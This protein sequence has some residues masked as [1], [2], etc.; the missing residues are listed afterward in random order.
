ML[1]LLGTL[2]YVHYF[3]YVYI[4]CMCQFHCVDLGHACSQFP[5]PSYSHLVY[6]HIFNH[7]C[8]LWH[9][10]VKYQ[11]WSLQQQQESTSLASGRTFFTYISLNEWGTYNRDIQW[12]C[13]SS[14]INETSVIDICAWEEAPTAYPRVVYASIILFN[15]NKHSH[16]KVGSTCSSQNGSVM[17]CLALV[18]SSCVMWRNTTG[19][20]HV[21]IELS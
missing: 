10:P 15:L 7:P 21:Q 11:S 2:R 3:W 6:I 9:Q 14:H 20:F 4:G 5:T 8:V 17:P 13:Q 12:D 19:R 16:S 1:K 18:H